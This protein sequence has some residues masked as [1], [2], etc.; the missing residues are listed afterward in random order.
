VTRPLP[1]STLSPL[2][3]DLSIL[4]MK[5]KNAEEE[6]AKGCSKAVMEE[7]SKACIKSAP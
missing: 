6:V 7:S 3:L 5:D 2:G 1:F 4:L